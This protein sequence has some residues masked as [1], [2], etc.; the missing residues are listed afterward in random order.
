MF[1]FVCSCNCNIKTCYH[2]MIFYVF[3]I[4]F[5]H[6]KNSIKRV[7]TKFGT[8]LLVTHD[9]LCV[10]KICSC[11]KIEDPQIVQKRIRMGKKA[12]CCVCMCIFSIAHNVGSLSLLL[13]I[14]T[15]MLTK[16]LLSEFLCNLTVVIVNTMLF[17]YFFFEAANLFYSLIISHLAFSQAKKAWSTTCDFLQNVF[18]DLKILLM[19]IG[20][21]TKNSSFT[22][23][24][25]PQY[26]EV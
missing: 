2:R 5:L 6:R 7:G 22:W 20:A 21:Y 8:W 3:L 26:L 16:S 25:C 15:W 24:F 17:W 4:I 9:K 1:L 13:W 14:C 11:R 19:L 12:P 18:H 23:L 10:E